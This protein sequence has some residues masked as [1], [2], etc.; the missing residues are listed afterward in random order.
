MFLE[1]GYHGAS[2]DAVA[3]AAGFSTGAVYSA[4]HN[5]AGLFL[6]VL[7]AHLADR[8]GTMERTVAAAASPAEHAELLARQ[9]ASASGH[10][11]AWSLLV[12]E[13]WADAAREPE[14]RREFAERHDTLKAAI[15]RMLDE[16][17]ARTGGRLHSR[18]ARR[19]RR[20]RARQRADARAARA[21]GRDARRAVRRLRR[22]DHG[23]AH[24]R[25][26]GGMSAAA[27]ADA[28]VALRRSRALLRNERWTGA[29]LRAHQRARL[30]ELVRHARSHSPF[31]RE[32]YRDVDDDDE[33][34]L[35]RLPVVT[36]AAMM[37]RFDEVVTDPRLR[38]RDLE[39]HL[40]R[41][42]RDELYLGRYRVLSTGGSTGRMG[43]FVADRDE[44][45]GYLAG[46][47][48]ITSTSDCGRGCPGAGGSR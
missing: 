46:V 30:T 35:E 33:I 15:A 14:L 36:K 47:L 48:R 22:A 18:P 23:G 31:Y 8:I 32:L 13:F 45:R 44:W 11:R 4:F 6:A 21:S 38:L 17:L 26:R 41:L 10:D 19:D 1:R 42:G 7:D 3:V 39:A 40:E 34:A 2:L 9:F 20:G 27:L 25:G 28:A 12:I 5:K 29:Q 16:M 24:A 43:V 37:E